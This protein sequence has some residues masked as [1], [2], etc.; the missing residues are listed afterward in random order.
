MAK[1]L[2]AVASQL[3]LRRLMLFLIIF[4]GLLHT[5][6]HT[7]DVLQNSRSAAQQELHALDCAP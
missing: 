5:V 4:I 3:H 7:A 2:G 6:L 1:H